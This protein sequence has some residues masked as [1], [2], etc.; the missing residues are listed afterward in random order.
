MKITTNRLK[1]CNRV[2]EKMKELTIANPKQYPYD[3]D[4][5]YILGFVHDVGYGLGASPKNHA[6][7]GAEILK[8]SGYKYWK[9]VYYHTSDQDVYNSPALT[10]LNFADLTTSPN[11]E[12]MSIP[13]RIG[14]I[15]AR[16]GQGSEQVNDALAVMNKLK[17]LGYPVL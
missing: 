7:V 4:E 11:G 16:Y 2:A 12:D 10:L 14:D 17:K 1:H 15:S 8:N 6:F 9:E 13:E 5:M 3:P